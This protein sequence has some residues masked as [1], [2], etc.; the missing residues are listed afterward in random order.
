[1]LIN[2]PRVTDLLRK[3]QLFELREVMARNSEIG[4]CTFDQSLYELYRRGLISYTDAIHY[5]ESANDLRLQIRSNGD[6]D[7]SQNTFDNVT[8]DL[9]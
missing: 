9:G 5:A 4:M 7:F 1:I 8:V 2:T 3:N 6:E